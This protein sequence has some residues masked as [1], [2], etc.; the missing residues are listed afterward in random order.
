MNFLESLD[1]NKVQQ[2]SKLPVSFI[3]EV[4]SAVAEQDLPEVRYRDFNERGV[5]LLSGAYLSVWRAYQYL[6]EL[7]SD[8]IE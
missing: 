5:V 1:K 4:F 6:V 2:L 3:K 7:A 8:Y